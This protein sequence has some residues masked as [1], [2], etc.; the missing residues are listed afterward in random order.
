MTPQERDLITH[1]L[2]RLAQAGNQPKDPE[3]DSLIRQAVAAQPDAPY[4]LVQ[5]VLI[6][7]MAL[8][9]A[10]SRIQALEQQLAAAKPAPAQ[11]TS[12][13]GGL[14][15][16]AAATNPAGSSVPSAGP[17]SR[18]AP[19]A[20][21]QAAPQWQG[22]PGP[23]QPWQGQPGY[24]PPGYGMGMSGPMMGMGGGSGFLR[25]AATTAAGIA[26]GALLFEGIQSMFGNHAGG[27]LSGTSMQPGLSET[28]INNY[29]GSDPAA[30]NAPQTAA[31]DHGTDSNVEPA[32]YTADN[33]VDPDPGLADQDFASDQDFGGGDSDL[34]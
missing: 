13:L 16:G 19:A 14:F 32:D 34:T 24:G 26:G 25:S 5:T 1:L 30:G 29:Y 2:D 33:T 6:Q 20:P 28:V 3:A 21:A 17:W 4:Y 27:I 10:Q 15:G 9:N 11:P 7:D 8:S 31:S 22:Q 23:A 12:F 18:P